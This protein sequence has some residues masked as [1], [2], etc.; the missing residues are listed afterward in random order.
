MTIILHY[1]C[2]RLRV[3]VEEVV[4]V[5][6]PYHVGALSACRIIISLKNNL[7]SFGGW[8][9]AREVMRE[10]TNASFE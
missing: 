2:I 3:V 8:L 5:K 7:S 1:H 10:C 4:A 9:C 6:G